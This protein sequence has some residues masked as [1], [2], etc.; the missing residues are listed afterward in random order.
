MT[1]EQIGEIIG[2]YA[3]IIL[4]IY[5]AHR[6]R[7]Q[8]RQWR[9]LIAIVTLPGS[10]IYRIFMFF[11]RIISSFVIGLKEGRGEKK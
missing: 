2:S 9:I 3:W 1:P 5:I 11:K 7:H 6:T 8:E 10:V 4:G